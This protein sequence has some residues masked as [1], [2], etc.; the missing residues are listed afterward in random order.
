[1][2]LSTYRYQLI[3]LSNNRERGII[4][5]ILT[6]NISAKAWERL[7]LALLESWDNISSNILKK[8]GFTVVYIRIKIFR[9]LSLGE[10]VLNSGYL[11]ICIKFSGEILGTRLQSKSEN[12]VYFKNS[13]TQ[14]FVY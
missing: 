4:D 7:D 13:N 8:F 11:I 14:N 1:M 3:T 2:M 6:M 10:S 5:S 9:I 12:I